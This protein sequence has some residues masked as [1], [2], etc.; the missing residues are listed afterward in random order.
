MATFSWTP[1]HD[2]YFKYSTLLSLWSIKELIKIPAT[3]DAKHIT[4][5]NHIV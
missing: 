4:F 1:Q 3:W 5:S 2:I